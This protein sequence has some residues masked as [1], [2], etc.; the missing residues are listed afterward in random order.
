MAD[1]SR[2]IRR[3]ALWLGA[4]P[5]LACLAL[6]WWLGRYP[7]AQALP[8]RDRPYGW[9]LDPMAQFGHWVALGGGVVFGLIAALLL[10]A[11][12]GRGRS[13]PSGQKPQDNRDEGGGPASR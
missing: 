8:Q 6:A 4:L 12:H 11:A 13:L 2:R 9:L 7:G 3:L 1:A 10:V 5:A